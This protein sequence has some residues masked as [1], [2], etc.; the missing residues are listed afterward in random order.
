M[1]CSLHY[2]V[3]HFGWIDHPATPLLDQEDATEWLLGTP[4]PV[5]SEIWDILQILVAQSSLLSKISK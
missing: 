3:R 5:G 2:F 1:C 4:Q